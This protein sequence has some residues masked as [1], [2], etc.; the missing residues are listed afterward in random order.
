M[1]RAGELTNFMIKTLIYRAPLAVL[2]LALAAPLSGCKEKEQAGPPKPPEV[3]VYTVKQMDVPIYRDWVGTLEGD[4]NA[5]ITAQVT[6]YLI[7]RNYTEGSLVTN[8]QVL[9]Q[10]DKGPFQAALDSANAQLVQAQAQRDKYALN[11]ERYKKLVITQAISQ[12]ELDDAVQNEK[13]AA[14]QVEGAKAAVEQAR[15]NLGFT[16]ICS[17]LDGLAGLAKAQVGNLIGPNSGLLTTVTKI[18]PIRVY[19]SLSQRL[20]T[21]LEERRLADGKAAFRSGDQGAELE[22]VLATG[23]I[24]PQKGY[25]RFA[26][27]QVDVKTGTVTIVGEFPNPNMLLVPGMFVRVRALLDTQKNALLVPQ[28]AVTDMQGKYLIAIVGADNKVSIRPVTAGERYGE[29]WVISGNVKAGD[30]VVAEGIQKVREGS[31]VNPV[32]FTE[33]GTTAAAPA[34]PPPAEARKQ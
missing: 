20:L 1:R 30:R 7:S 29:Q 12:Q 26:N 8:G 28:R 11:V 3:E 24:Y 6:G 4:V 34:A 9:F 33:Q 21:Q 10:I 2:V 27:N 17:P 5:T 22:L 31:V 18:E 16:T 15:L 25:V 14:G 32:P 13:T 23:S 19:F